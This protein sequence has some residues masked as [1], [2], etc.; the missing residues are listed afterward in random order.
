MLIDSEKQKWIRTYLA[1]LLVELL[2]NLAPLSNGIAERSKALDQTLGVDLDH[3]AETTEC[4]VLL[5][6]VADCTASVAPGLSKHLQVRSDQLRADQSETTNGDGRVVQKGTGSG[7][8]GEQGD[9][10]LE[11]RLDPDGHSLA[12]LKSNLSS[13]PGGVIA[14]RDVF[15]VGLDLVDQ[16]V[17]ESVQVWLDV[18][19]AADGEI[20]QES[21]GRLANF[22]RGILQKK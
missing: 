12:V 13:S 22:G 3:L 16:L 1:E 7:F 21:I 4:S 8:A 19:E 11:Q 14:D 5:L 18:Q 6:V 10:A 20:S 2:G 17:H 9:Q 15:G